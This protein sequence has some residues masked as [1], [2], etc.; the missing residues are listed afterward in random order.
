MKRCA[1][2]TL[3]CKANSYDTQ[4]LRE[5]VLRAGYQEVPADRPADL[6]VVNTCTVTHRSGRKSRQVIHRLIRDNPAALVVVT[7]CYA[8]SDREALLAIEGVDLVVGNADKTRLTE[9]IR[10]C[11]GHR[12]LPP[13][14]LWGPDAEAPLAAG[15]TRFEGQTRAF[16]KIEDGCDVFCSFCI[17]PYVRGPVRSRTPDEVVAE[18]AALAEA[19][20]REVVLT[21]IHLGGYGQDTDAPGA[22]AAGALVRLLARLDEETGLERVRISS[23]DCWEIDEALL[24]AVAALP[25]VA[26][27]LHI[28]LQAGSDQVL[29]R[30]RRRYTGARF[31]E[32]VEQARARV[33][34]LALTTDV[35]VG[36][37]GETEDDFQRTLA[38]CR[39]AGFMKI[40]VFPYSD[41][42]GTAAARFGGKV[43]PEEKG[44]RV[45]RVEA[46]EAELGLAYRRRFVGRAVPVLVEES[47]DATTGKL[48]G[49]SDRYVR[50]LLD[51]P[52]ALMNRVLPV[53]IERATA[54][55]AHGHLAA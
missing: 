18:C 54:S 37:P 25:T 14:P 7:G 5:Q 10:D 6:F 39:E 24:D 31:L 17:I 28:P 8:E 45:D 41:R 3:G 35:I 2:V 44:A 33:P 51:G 29:E 26:A 4:V 22:P 16:V 34:E 43:S 9:L 38:V 53:Q 52:D 47:R 42:Q 40:H 27:H 21:G 30:M 11:P 23:I 15:I 36:F 49:Y 46:L 20:Y 12:E 32:V 55:E 13:L 48:V 19:G 1:F 50:T